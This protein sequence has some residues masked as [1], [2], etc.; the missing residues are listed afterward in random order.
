[1]SHKFVCNVSFPHL[2]EPRLRKLLETF[3]YFFDS[4][5]IAS[6]ADSM[7]IVFNPAMLQ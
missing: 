1:M 2:R 5:N 4:L 6:I 7:G 3:P